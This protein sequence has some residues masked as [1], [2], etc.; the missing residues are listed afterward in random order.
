ML[1]EI[2]ENFIESHQPF[3][4][5]VQIRC[6]AACNCVIRVSN[7]NSTTVVPTTKTSSLFY[8]T[9]GSYVRHRVG[10]FVMKTCKTYQTLMIFSCPL[11][12]SVVL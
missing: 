12:N 5:K 2:H 10:I 7:V 8:P 11:L 6:L 1:S 3:V 9:E 4:E